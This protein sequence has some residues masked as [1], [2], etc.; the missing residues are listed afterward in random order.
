MSDGV[1][2]CNPADVLKQKLVV[3]LYLYNKVTK[4]MVSFLR[5]TTM[6]ARTRSAEPL[7]LPSNWSFKGRKASGDK[8][9]S[10]ENLMLCD[11]GKRVLQDIGDDKVAVICVTGPARSGKSYLLSKLVDDVS[12][13][14]GHEVFSK[15]TG[16]WVACSKCEIQEGEEKARIVYS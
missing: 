11:E 10:R 12:F 13:D 4:S 15:T 2:F 1:T 16:I 3:D 9:K 8:L 5:R 6:A 7:C 14:V